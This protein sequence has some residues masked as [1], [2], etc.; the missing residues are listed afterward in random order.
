MNCADTSEKLFFLLMKNTHIVLHVEKEIFCVSCN[1]FV[2]I[3][4]RA[5]KFPKMDHLNKISAPFQL[6]FSSVGFAAS[7]QTS[8]TLFHPTLF[9]KTLKKTVFVLHW[10]RSLIQVGVWSRELPFFC[11]NYHLLN[12]KSLKLVPDKNRRFHWTGLF[13]IIF[14]MFLC[15]KL[16]S[17]P[18]FC[19]LF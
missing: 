19:L 6:L 18:T 2:P 5:L 15:W 12:G 13:S 4:N 9:S 8:V 16:F 10:W 3:Y 7:L 1:S 17:L 11:E 14:F